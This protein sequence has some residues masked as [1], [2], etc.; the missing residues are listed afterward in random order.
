MQ[1]V[2]LSSLCR[3]ERGNTI[4]Q[5]VLILPIFIILVF[6]SY[7]IWKLVHIKQTLEAATIQA[8]RYLSVEGRYLDTF[9]EDWEGRAWNII[10]EELAN[11]AILQDDLGAIELRVSVESRVGGHISG[12]E[13]PGEESRRA[14]RARRRAELAQFVVRSQLTVP[15]PVRIPLVVTADN[16]TLWE[17]QWHYLECGPNV[18]PTPLP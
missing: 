17:S 4:I 8:A 1:L 13:C 11:E 3:D 10:A 14:S 16:L 18:I 9:P 2:N 12:P 7:E 15:S 6:G 5:F